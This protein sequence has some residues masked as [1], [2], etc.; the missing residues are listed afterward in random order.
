MNSWQT[1]QSGNRI[2]VIKLGALGD[3]VLASAH[4]RRIVEA[5]PDAGV[6]LLTTPGCSELFRDQSGLE[7]IAFRRRGVAE[8]WRLFSWV[9]RQRFGVV[10]DLQGSQRSRIMTWCSGACRRI[11]ET[12][13]FAYTHAVVSRGDAVHIFD[14][15]NLLLASQ[16]IDAADPQERLSVHGTATSAVQ[17]WLDGHALDTA[18]LVLMHAGSSE[19]WLSKRWDAACFADLAAEL[20]RRGCK[21][22]WIGAD[23]DAAVN[24]QL[25]GRAG[26]DATGAFSLVQLAALGG[27]ASFAVV[28]DSAPM[29]VLA[30]TGLPVYAL[31]GPTD[32][33][34]SH[35]P[36]QEQHV[37]YHA[38]DCS[39]CFLPVCPPERGHACL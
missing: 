32:W 4:I 16:G 28:N 22:I 30:A 39:P 9:R 2:L 23:E 1:M 20:E 26:I 15:L 21:V 19:R 10:F 33:R 38:V 35:A 29:H 34:R 31:F 36:G 11:G 13:C 8:M 24:R 3:V 17:T 5:Y 27:R 12:P 18:K 7:V 25:A 37:L 14:R 6:T